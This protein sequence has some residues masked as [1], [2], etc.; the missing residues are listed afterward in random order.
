[1]PSKE[2]KDLAR[3]RFIEHVEG[4]DLDLLSAL[5]NR[6][7]LGISLSTCQIYIEDLA[8]DQYALN[9]IIIYSDLVLMSNQIFKYYTSKVIWNKQVL[10]DFL[11]ESGYWQKEGLKWGI[12][13]DYVIPEDLV[14]IIS[15]YYDKPKLILRCY[16]T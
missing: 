1:M 12:A 8:I 16:K 4:L 9:N 14:Y 3:L 10:V 13:K 7:S 5:F 2:Q 15:D 11:K 6:N